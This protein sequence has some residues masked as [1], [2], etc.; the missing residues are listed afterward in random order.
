MLG[1]TRRKLCLLGFLAV[2]TLACGR[3]QG[4]SSA[5]MVSSAHRELVGRW[6]LIRY[7][8]EE[9][10]EPMLANLLNAQIGVMTLE[11]NGQTMKANGM[12]ITTERAYQVIEATGTQFRLVLRDPDGVTYNVAAAFQGSELE[13][14]SQ[15]S[16]WRGRGRLRRL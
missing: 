14:V 13:F 4:A 12:G 3:K 11:F 9:A 15:T 8:P 10:L 5:D 7:Q 1:L 16:P 6:V 2:G